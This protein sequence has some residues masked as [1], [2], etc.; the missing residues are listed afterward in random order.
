[1]N[2]SSIFNIKRK[3]SLHLLMSYLPKMRKLEI[4]Q[5]NKR[6]QHA[7][8]IKEVLYE[9][10]SLKNTNQSASYN[11]S[12]TSADDF[13]KREILTSL[14][15]ISNLPFFNGIGFTL[16]GH[17]K[18]ISNIIN[19][20]PFDLS[21][22]STTKI[23]S[24]SWDSTIKIWDITSQSL[25]ASLPPVSEEDIIIA[26]IPLYTSHTLQNKKNP[27]LLMAVTWDKKIIIYNIITNTIHY[28]TTIEQYGK[29]LW[30]I[31]CDNYLLTS[32]Y[33]HDIRVWTIPNFF[34]EESLIE[35]LLKRPEDANDNNKRFTCVHILKGHNDAI[36]RMIQLK[37]KRIASCSWD[38]TIRIWNL[39]TFGC[40]HT[41]KVYED[42]LT[43]LLQLNDNRLAC[44]SLNGVVRVL[45]L[46]SK[47]FDVE[48]EGSDFMFQLR[49][50]RMVTG[51]GEETFQVINLNT[52]KVELV[53]RTAHVDN[54]S[55]FLQLNDGRVI[56]A[57][58]DNDIKVYGFVTK[59]ELQHEAYDYEFKY[60]KEC[61]YITHK[62]KMC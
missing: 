47:K 36:P 52:L 46:S 32:S 39:N 35:A 42:K 25:Y 62:S 51:I 31:K 24:Y 33:E 26:V 13:T 1:M 11:L 10:Y 34:H 41:F 20:P 3:R 43:Q 28:Q 18:R 15:E 49:D 55:A 57:S 38:R 59:H 4:V 6:L 30:A 16:R 50:G 56:T 60:E 61:L 22:T 21:T 44:L 54:I 37:D 8:K 58:F 12:T 17:S 27:I 9:I 5:K 19:L 23:V 14:F 2:S 29:L 48:F 53:F 45:N 40:E 7:L